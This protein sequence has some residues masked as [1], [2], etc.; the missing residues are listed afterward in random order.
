MSTASQVQSSRDGA[1]SGSGTSPRPASSSTA[2][3][4]VQEK[5]RVEQEQESASRSL[6]NRVNTHP[7]E[8]AGL[9]RNR[10]LWLFRL[11]YLSKMVSHE[12]IGSFSCE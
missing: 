4:K 11:S 5:K 6:L 10:V 2:M 1:S 8:G 9:L 12:T 3:P 7:A